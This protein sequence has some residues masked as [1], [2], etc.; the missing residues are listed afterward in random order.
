MEVWVP[1]RGVQHVG[2]GPYGSIMGSEKFS[3]STKER[4]APLAS[5]SR[6]QVFGCA[7][8]RIWGSYHSSKFRFNW[9][10][11]GKVSVNR[12]LKSY[13]FKLKIKC[14]IKTLKESNKPIRKATGF[15]EVLNWKSLLNASNWSRT[16]S[17]ESFW[18]VLLC[19]SQRN[20]RLA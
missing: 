5:L 6:G 2:V 14:K 16:P 15:C 8:F 4:P 11:L 10:G 20:P 13:L 19:G 17:I 1:Q 18:R 7:N 3:V 9:S 12:Y